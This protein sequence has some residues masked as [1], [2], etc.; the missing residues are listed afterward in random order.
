[1]LAETLE[2]ATSG[3]WLASNNLTLS[4][5]TS[6]EDRKTEYLS[7][8]RIHSVYQILARRCIMSVSPVS[9]VD[10][11]YQTY[12]ANWQNNVS[13]TRQGFNNLANALQAG[14]LSDAQSAFTALQ[15]LLPNSSADNQAQTGQS[16]SGQNQFATDF[17]ALGQALQSGDVTQAQK[18]FATLQQDMQSVQGHHHHRH[19]HGSASTQSTNS[20]TS[21]SSA[22]ST[23]G[24]GQNQFATDFSALG[25]AL[26]SSDLSKAQQAYAKL[27]QDMG[28]VAGNFNFSV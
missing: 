25:Q 15:Q 6:G 16:G 28:S 4:P 11:T 10:Y 12:Q 26:Q 5:T 1:M 22:Q 20:P 23:T 13:Q 3:I 7:S 24:S 21:N 9:S 27:Q 17:S 19:H 8:I 2:W 18:A 14:N